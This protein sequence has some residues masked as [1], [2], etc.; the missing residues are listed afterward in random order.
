MSKH[1]K[2]HHP[3]DLDLKGNPGIGQSAG[4]DNKRTTFEDE[5]GE[6]TVEGDVMNETTRQGGIDPAHRGRTNK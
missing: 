5:A 4:I 3:N 2:G 6:N 1:S